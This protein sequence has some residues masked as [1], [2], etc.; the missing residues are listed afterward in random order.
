ML[1]W[2]RD[3]RAESKPPSREGDP[4]LVLQEGDGGSHVQALSSTFGNRFKELFP[5]ND[6]G[7]LSNVGT[8]QPGQSRHPSDVFEGLQRDPNS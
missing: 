6:A 4:D 7:E 3:P 1:G 5:R 8:A 2:L